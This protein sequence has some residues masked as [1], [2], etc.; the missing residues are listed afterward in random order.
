MRHDQHLYHSWIPMVRWMTRNPMRW[1][2]GIAWYF[3][4]LQ[5]RSYPVIPRN[6]NFNGNTNIW[7]PLEFWNWGYPIRQ[8]HDCKFMFLFILLFV[9][10]FQCS[11]LSVKK[12]TPCSVFT[13]IGGDYPCVF[14]VNSHV[15]SCWAVFK[16]AVGLWLF[17]GLSYPLYIGDYNNLR[18]G[19][20]V[21][22]PGLN[23]MTEGFCRKCSW[24]PLRFASPAW[25]PSL[26]TPWSA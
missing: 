20:P 11:V 10:T 25:F 12:P 19:N 2:N 17:R 24:G 3:L 9:V 1:C 14:V 21:S 5:K 18:T 13:P 22:Q 26:S 8:N 7:H 6:C 4:F 15:I 23:G 16:T